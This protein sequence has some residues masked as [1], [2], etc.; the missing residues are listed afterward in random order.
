MAGNE[1]A[2]L[3]KHGVNT[4]NRPVYSQS[5]QNNVRHLMSRSSANKRP[6]Y[7]HNKENQENVTYVNAN[8]N[9]KQSTPLAVA[10]NSWSKLHPLQS[11]LLNPYLYEDYRVYREKYETG[12]HGMSNPNAKK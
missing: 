7:V 8:N 11:N 5:N 3:Q 9:S 1:E 6:S 12:D 4:K 10:S 2:N